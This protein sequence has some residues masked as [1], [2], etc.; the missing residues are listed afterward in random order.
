MHDAEHNDL[1]FKRVFHGLLLLET[2]TAYL[3]L[4]RL[5]TLGYLLNIN[6]SKSLLYGMLNKELRLR[7]SVQANL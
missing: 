3:M 5:E 6:G 2:N 7:G 1:N 4:L